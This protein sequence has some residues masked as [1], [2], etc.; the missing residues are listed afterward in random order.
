ME[1][2]RREGFLLP[3]LPWK[4]K[5]Y[6]VLRGMYETVRAENLKPED[7]RKDA[8]EKS[9]DASVM[10]L[11]LQKKNS[12]KVSFEKEKILTPEKNL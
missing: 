8:A 7:F 10:V 1:V 3:Y 4:M 11:L 6:I 9:V 2:R 12:T 5:N